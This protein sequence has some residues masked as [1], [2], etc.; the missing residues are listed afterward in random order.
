MA[1]VSSATTPVSY[2]HLIPKF[3]AQDALRDRGQQAG[4]LRDEAGQQHEARRQRK[5]EAVYDLVRRDDAHVLRIG[6]GGQAAEEAAEHVCN[7]VA[8]DA[9][10]ELIV[11]RL[12]VHAADG[13]GG[14][15]AYR[16]HGV[17]GEEQTE[18]DTG[19]DVKVH[20]RCV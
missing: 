6:R 19:R 2:T 5:D 15:V 4:E 14:E 11:R 3:S 16:L 17:N 8:E 1:R 10:L 18:S 13:R 7:A 20:A 12:P 9:A